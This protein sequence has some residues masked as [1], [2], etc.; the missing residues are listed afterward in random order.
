VEPIEGAQHYIPRASFDDVAEQDDDGGSCQYKE[1]YSIR[2][3]QVPVLLYLCS[4]S[5]EIA[6]LHYKL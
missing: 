6:L 4:E 5:R 2:K 1:H 3:Q